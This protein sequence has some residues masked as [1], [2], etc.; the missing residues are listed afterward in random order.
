MKQMWT[1]SENNILA[2]LQD[3]VALQSVNPDLPGGN[4]GECLMV[5]DWLMG[6]VWFMDV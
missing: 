4:H 3:V 1:R 6:V 5:D 2:T